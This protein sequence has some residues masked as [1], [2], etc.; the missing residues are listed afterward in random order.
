[1]VPYCQAGEPA[2]EDAGGGVYLSAQFL[3]DDLVATGSEVSQSQP[4]NSVAEGTVEHFRFPIAVPADARFIR[5]RI[6]FKDTGGNASN[7]GYVY[8][9]YAGDQPR[10]Y[11][12]TFACSA[13]NLTAD[14]TRGIYL[15]SGN[16]LGDPVTDT[17]R[18]RPV[19][20]GWIDFIS[21]Q[22]DAKLT[23]GTA[24]YRVYDETAAAY[25]GPTATIT[26]AVAYVHA[27]DDY[28]ATTNSFIQG[29]KL[30]VA[31][32]GSAGLSPAT[33]D[34]LVHV[35]VTMIARE[36]GETT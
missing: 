4:Q 6:G 19:S 1:M 26:N 33:T 30:R 2:V 9:I 10:L 32:V 8:Q 14:G 31:A 16:T 29:A 17:N 15:V 21:V 13:I 34:S 24:A 11:H 23:A 28:D 36:D 3:D 7:T 27:T 20:D 25:V 18:F 12:A 5:V 35:G 22:V